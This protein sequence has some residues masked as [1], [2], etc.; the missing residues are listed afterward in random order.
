MSVVWCVRV[1]IP[2]ND[3][4]KLT[5]FNSS[6]HKQSVSVTTIT[7]FVF[8]NRI[9][10][11]AEQ[12]SVVQRNT[13]RRIQH[14]S[15]LLLLLFSPALQPSTGYGLLLSRGFLITHNDAPQ[16]VGLLWTSYHLVA[17]TSSWQHTTNIHAPGR[18]RTHDGSKRAALDL[19]LRP[20]SHWDRHFFQLVQYKLISLYATHRAYVTQTFWGTDAPP[21]QFQTND[22]LLC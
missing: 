19:R 7:N 5:V 15:Q 22:I 11:P 2:E 18:I 21:D 10:W 13:E 3:V 1:H 4:N 17:E 6:E 8:R 20:R 12:Q 16:S 9:F 14:F